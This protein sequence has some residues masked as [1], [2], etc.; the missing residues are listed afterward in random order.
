MRKATFLGDKTF[1]IESFTLP[2][3]GPGELLVRNAACGVCGTDVHIY[4]GEAGSA[5]VTPPVVLGH[6]YS[7]VVEAVG[8]SV[9]NFKAGDHVTI[10]PNIYCGICRFCRAGKKQ[11][12]EEMRAIGVTQ[13][14]GFATHSLIP[15][16]QA[17]LLDK[18]LSPESGAMA[19]PLAC[20]IHG[21]DQAGIRV[22]DTVLVV[23]G[24]TI[25]L[26]MLQLAKLAGAARV[27]VSE[28]VALRREIALGL[29]AE[30]CIDPIRENPAERIRELGDRDGADVV[31]EC[32][33]NTAATAQAFEA[34]AKGA[35]LLLFS[36]PAVDASFP[37]SLFDVYKKELTIKGSFINPDTHERAVALL[38]SGRIQI[39]PLITHRFGLDELEKA[40]HTQ[41]SSESIKVLVIPD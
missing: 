1:R 38:E 35:T 3:P 5:E 13:D 39:E 25:G 17:Y 15:A 6:E 19:E 21:I 30:A 41:M 11:L 20:C 26:L 16:S 34:A 32:A 28:P 33:G 10:D 12:C 8:E 31:I 27:Y 7:A 40:I 36:V 23:G 37:L 2:E 29:G 9:V 14:G 18:N 4:F 22:G 24:G